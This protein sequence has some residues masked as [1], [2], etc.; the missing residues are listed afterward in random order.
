ME[1]KFPLEGKKVENKVKFP[2]EG[3]KEKIIEFQKNDIIILPYLKE[4]VKLDLSK[5]YIEALFNEEFNICENYYQAQWSMI[6]GILSSNTNVDY[7]VENFDNI[8]NGGLW[9]LIKNNIDNYN[10]FIL[11]LKNIVNYEYQKRSIGNSINKLANKTIDL[12]N[13]IGTLDLSEEG[14][15]KLLKSIQDKT[16]ELKNAP[17]ELKEKKLTKKQG[18]AKEE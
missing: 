10:D 9:D 1:E 16:D 14:I 4:E 7:D 3:K 6:I 2:F 5:N 13:Y 8:V 15:S 17:I 12:I 18:K 11:D